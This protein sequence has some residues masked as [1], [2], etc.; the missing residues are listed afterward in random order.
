[1][2]RA[3]ILTILIALA[4]LLVLVAVYRSCRSGSRPPAEGGGMEEATYRASAGTD[5]AFHALA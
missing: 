5:G 3:R 4:L 1:M 2:N